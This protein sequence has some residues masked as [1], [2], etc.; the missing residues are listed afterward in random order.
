MADDDFQCN[1]FRLNCHRSRDH[2]YF[3]QN[4][5]HEQ[6]IHMH[7]YKSLSTLVRPNIKWYRLKKQQKLA[8]VCL[9]LCINYADCRGLIKSQKVTCVWC[10]VVK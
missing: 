4:S 9:E 2:L 8:T 5:H 10:R 6:V 7:L 1:A 3:A